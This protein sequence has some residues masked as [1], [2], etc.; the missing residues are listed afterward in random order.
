MNMMR[1]PVLVLNASYEA[2]RIVAA[3]RAMTLITKGAAVTEV[4]TNLQ[5]Y[6]G[7]YLPSVIRLRTYRHIPIRMQIASRRNIHLRD[8]GRCMYCGHKFR[9]DQLTLD[10]VLPRS[11]GG[12]SDWGNLV[13]ACHGCNR[14][15]A[16][17]TPEEW[18]VPLIHKPIPSSIHMSRWILRSMGMEE[19]AWRKYIYAD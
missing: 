11:R 6:P 3:R 15:K 17:R 2:I 18:G 9:H 10:H 7:I 5:A 1:Q 12:K 8:G 14:K 16:D 19:P 4:P 13:S